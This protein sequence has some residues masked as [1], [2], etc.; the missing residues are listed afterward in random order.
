MKSKTKDRQSP[1]ETKDRR[2]KVSHHLH[3]EMNMLQDL[4]EELLSGTIHREVIRNALLEA[5]GIHAR[6]LRDFFYNNRGKEDD[7]FAWEFTPCPYSWQKQPDPKLQRAINRVN[8]EFAHLTY[9]RLNRS[10]PEKKDWTEE[11]KLIYRELTDIF[12][13][14]LNEA[15]S[16]LLDPKLQKL[17]SDLNASEAQETEL[18]LSYMEGLQ[19]LHTGPWKNTTSG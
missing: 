1:P 13:E 15:S 4:R 3:Y 10:T 8:K 2:R 6:A 12:R 18:L 16:D 7:V 17:G 5:F 9:E 11:I 19:N 14:F